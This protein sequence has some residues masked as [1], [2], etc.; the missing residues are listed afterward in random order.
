MAM[1]VLVR[2]HKTENMAKPGQFAQ[3]QL[4]FSRAPLDARGTAAAVLEA[5]VAEQSETAPANAKVLAA[6]SLLFWTL[7]ITAGRLM[8]YLGPVSGL[9]E[10]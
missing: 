8:A 4:I 6:L 2:L 5:P 10:K 3:S 7:S 1:I 9:N